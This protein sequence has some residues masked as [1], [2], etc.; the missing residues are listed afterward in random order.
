MKARPGIASTRAVLLGFRTRSMLT[1]MGDATSPPVAQHVLS[2]VLLRRFAVDNGHGQKVVSFSLRFGHAARR[3]VASV[4]YLKNFI[5]HQPVE[6]EALWGELEHRMPE[7]F[8]HLD[9]GDLRAHP[10]LVELMKQF[11]ALHFIRREN[12]RR[13]FETNKAKRLATASPLAQQLVE[14][15]LESLFTDTASEQFARARLDVKLV[16][17]E[18]GTAAEGEFL[19]PDV[20]VVAV[21]SGQVIAAPLWGPGGRYFPVGPKHVICLAP[22]PLDFTFPREDVDRLNQLFT[23][24]AQATVFFRPGAGLEDAIRTWRPP[25]GA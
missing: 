23:A 20:G 11:L 21:K 24:A 3:P 2:K 15:Q 7:V 8:R 6:A 10:E 12:T 14:T 19:L 4:G 18:I 22:A 17:L 9:A 1:D 16:H 25:A 5:I 13:I